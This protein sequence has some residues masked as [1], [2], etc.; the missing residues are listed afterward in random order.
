MQE[1]PPSA[2]SFPSSV[3]R[4]E[5]VLSLG[6]TAYAH[7]AFCCGVFLSSQSHTRGTAISE[8]IEWYLK[9]YRKFLPV[10]LSKNPAS[11]KRLYFKL[12]ENMLQDRCIL[13]CHNSVGERVL[14]YNPQFLLWAWEEGAKQYESSFD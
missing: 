8:V 3:R 6:F 9:E 5:Q 13:E 2:I 7:F 11:L 4:E 10:K 12:V 14:R 1:Q